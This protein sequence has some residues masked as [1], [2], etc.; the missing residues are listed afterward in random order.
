MPISLKCLQKINK[1]SEKLQIWTNLKNKVTFNF[2]SESTIG[3]I[4]TIIYYVYIVA[5][6]FFFV[7]CEMHTGKR[8]RS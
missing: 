2:F 8:L 6:L 5:V 1:W 4:D 3:P 7:F